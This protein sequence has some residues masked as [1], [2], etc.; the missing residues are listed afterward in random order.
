MHVKQVKIAKWVRAVMN[1]C[2]GWGQ[3]SSR[4][5]EVSKMPWLRM[6]HDDR[7]WATGL[8]SQGE[9]PLAPWSEH[10]QGQFTNPWDADPEDY[11]GRL[12]ESQ[13]IS[14]CLQSI[15]ILQLRQGLGFAMANASLLS[16]SMIWTEQNLRW[17]RKG[18]HGNKMPWFFLLCGE[19]SQMQTEWITLSSHY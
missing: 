17:E 15:K 1:C 4:P 8:Q 14:I 11:K 18:E 12:L 7:H 6:K 2:W 13:E 10:G 16:I 19:L 3:I 5:R 9:L